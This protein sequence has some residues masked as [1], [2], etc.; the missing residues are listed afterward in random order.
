MPNN[1]STK[2]QKEFQKQSLSSFV[3]TSF[4]LSVIFAHMPYC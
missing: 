4:S 1:L 2:V 3:I